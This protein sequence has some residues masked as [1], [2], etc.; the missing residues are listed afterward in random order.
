MDRQIINKI[1]AGDTSITNVTELKNQLI[2]VI[3]IIQKT[4][5]SKENLIITLEI[6]E[7]ATA[8]INNIGESTF[9]L[10][11]SGSSFTTVDE[12]AP[13]WFFPIKPALAPSHKTNTLPL[14]H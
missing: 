13:Q 6:L 12:I 9:I 11:K 4:I 8:M 14:V 7:N 5:K 10:L 2:E 1:T 3:S